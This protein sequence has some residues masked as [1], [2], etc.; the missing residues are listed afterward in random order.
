MCAALTACPESIGEGRKPLPFAVDRLLSLN[1]SSSDEG[2][3]VLARQEG[4]PLRFVTRVS[5]TP[6]LSA[7]TRGRKY[8]FELRLLYCLRITV[9]KGQC[10]AH[11]V[12]S[13]HSKRLTSAFSVVLLARRK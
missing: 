1:T 8:S 7:I 12:A 6:G 13:K 4:T 5:Y 10:F 2:V 11:S 9:P 3:V